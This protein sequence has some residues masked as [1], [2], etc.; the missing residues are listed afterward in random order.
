MTKVV[1]RALYILCAVIMVTLVV[2]NG[3]LLAKDKPINLL[4]GTIDATRGPFSEATVKFAKDLEQRTEGRVKVNINWM[5][6]KPSEMFEMAQNG[7]ADI[8]WDTQTLMPGLFPLSEIFELPFV[9]PTAEIGTKAYIEYLKKGYVDKA[10]ENNVKLL[11]TFA[12]DAHNFIFNKKTI[13]KADEFKGMKI[14]VGGSAQ[15]KFIA[16]LGGVPVGM[17]MPEMYTSLQKGIIDGTI[18]G[19]PMLVQFRLFEVGKYVMGPPMIAGQAMCV[20]NE[21]KWNKLPADIQKIIGGMSEQ[22]AIE[23]ARSWD[24][25]SNM[26]KKLFLDN[27]GKMNDLNPE[28]LNKVSI[29]IAPVWE[30]WIH[31]MTEKGYNGKKAVDDMYNILKGLGVENPAVGYKPSM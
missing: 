28:E 18:F 8:A 26:G 31:E 2:G 17:P 30:G 5:M 24:G 23:F 21:A 25:F 16:S 11:W 6:A 14:G 10:Y 1:K 7:L 29:A 20:M 13:T 3:P 22:Y 15:A 4:L 27:G 19:F 12:S 9:I